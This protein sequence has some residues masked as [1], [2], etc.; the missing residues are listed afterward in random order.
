MFFFFSWSRGTVLAVFAIVE[1]LG[2]FRGAHLKVPYLPMLTLAC[3][4][5][6]HW[7]FHGNSLKLAL[8]PHKA[9]RD[10]GE[11]HFTEQAN[12]QKNTRIKLLQNKTI[13]LVSQ[14][15]SQTNNYRHLSF[16]KYICL[17]VTY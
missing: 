1:L 8:L 16:I 7:C 13:M 5:H 14:A 6:A 4:V 3:V 2:R 11:K 9:E 12:R 15:Y 17:I 10:S